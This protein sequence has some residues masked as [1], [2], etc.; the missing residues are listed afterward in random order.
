MYSLLSAF[1]SLPSTFYL[2]TFSSLFST[3]YTL[4]S[5]LLSTLYTLLSNY[6][7][8][9]LFCP[10]HSIFSSLPLLRHN[11]DMDYLRD[12]PPSLSSPLSPTP[13]PT[14]RE[15]YDRPVN[16]LCGLSSF[17]GPLL[18]FSSLYQ[19]SL[20]S[21]AKERLCTFARHTSEPTLSF[22]PLSV[23]LQLPCIMIFFY[24]HEQLYPSS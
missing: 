8:P 15:S 10:V 14:S 6:L 13:Y 7:R 9:F 3:L 16:N 18:F 17:F 11:V 12:L 20:L 21:F 5:T 4:P 19:S 23:P 1:Y 2:F 24:C 22:N